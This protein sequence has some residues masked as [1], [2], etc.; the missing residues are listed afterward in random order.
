M[1]VRECW[2]NYW[3]RNMETRPLTAR[4]NDFRPQLA[5]IR[6][7]HTEVI[8]ARTVVLSSRGESIVDAPYWLGKRNMKKQ[9]NTSYL[10]WGFF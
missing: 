1:I 8:G 6:P 10:V 2:R 5:G 4:S 7:F 3:N 9:G